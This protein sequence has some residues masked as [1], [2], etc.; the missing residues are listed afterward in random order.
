MCPKWIR[1]GARA[2]KIT[3]DVSHAGLV[4]H[5]G[6]QMDGFLGVILQI[7]SN[8]KTTFNPPLLDYTHLGE[9]LNLSAV[10]GS[11]L[12]GKETKG[13][14]TGSFVLDAIKITI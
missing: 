11:P 1:T 8:V 5:N 7:I 3:N 10:T 6:S 9:G 4:T 13:A 14:V 12:S 2:V